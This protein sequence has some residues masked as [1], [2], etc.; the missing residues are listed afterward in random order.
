LYATNNALEFYAPHYALKFYAPHNALR[1]LQ[2]AA[3]SSI[4]SSKNTIYKQQSHWHLR[5]AHRC[6]ATDCVA[7]H[8]HISKWIN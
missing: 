3:N 8:T 4:A 1:Y 6:T 2:P 5:T 7:Q